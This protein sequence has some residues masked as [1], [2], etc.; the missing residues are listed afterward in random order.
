MSLF[1]NDLYQWRETYFVVFEESR[2]PTAEAMKKKLLSLG[3]RYEL[4]N[5]SATEAGE[6]ESVTIFSP[7]DFAA[8]DIT[9]TSGEDVA[10]SIAVIQEQLLDAPL[11]KE[12]KAKLRRLPDCN[13][14]LDI[15]HFEQATSGEDEDEILDPGA[16]LIVLEQVATLCRGI[17]VDPQSGE[18]M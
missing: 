9:Y 8:M 12:E 17:G 3:D 10:E 7:T 15:Y 2:R 6:F 1:E 16:L 11:T 14:R 5:F 4:E 18:L 13:A